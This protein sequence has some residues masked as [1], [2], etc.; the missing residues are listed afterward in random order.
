[1]AARSFAGAVRFRERSKNCDLG[2][3]FDLAQRLA[4][5]GCALKGLGHG[6]S[7]AVDSER[8]KMDGEA[9]LSAGSGDLAVEGCW[10]WILS[11]P[12]TLQRTL[13]EPK[14]S[15]GG[16]GLEPCTTLPPPPGHSSGK[17]AF[18]SRPDC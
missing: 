7:D 10:G 14:E 5:L 15:R 16:S 13:S 6:P 1:M 8:S 4:P 2:Q 18:P 12:G 17:L 9:A 11:R 3:T